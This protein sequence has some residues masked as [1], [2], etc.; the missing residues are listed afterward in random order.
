MTF[1]VFTVSRG[2]QISDDDI[3]DTCSMH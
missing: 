2:V 3:G 1:L